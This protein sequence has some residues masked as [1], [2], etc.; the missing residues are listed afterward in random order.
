MART[1]C[2]WRRGPKAKIDFCKELFE[3]N[4]IRKNFKNKIAA[5]SSKIGE[6]R[7]IFFGRIAKGLTPNYVLAM[8]LIYPIIAVPI[9]I[10]IFYIIFWWS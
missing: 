4:R 6:I 1:Y 8:A 9:K 5:I 3:N 10:I 7:Q 2:T